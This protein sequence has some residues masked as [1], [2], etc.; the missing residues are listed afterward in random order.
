MNHVSIPEL[1]LLCG[2]HCIQ[3][4]YC[5]MLGGKSN[6]G[7]IGAVDQ[8][9]VRNKKV[10]LSLYSHCTLSAGSLETTDVLRLCFHARYS[11]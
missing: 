11:I 9:L 1:S 8:Q 5:K 6:H 2:R 4:Y 7:A 3:L 10:R